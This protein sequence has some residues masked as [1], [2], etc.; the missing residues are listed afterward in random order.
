M[1]SQRHLSCRAPAK[2][3]SSTLGP[4]GTRRASNG[5]ISLTNITD[6]SSIEVLPR[7]SRMPLLPQPDQHLPQPPPSQPDVLALMMNTVAIQYYDWTG[8]FKETVSEISFGFA[9]SIL[10]QV[11][12]ILLQQK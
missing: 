3:R 9:R 4:D 5:L 11:D 10:T 2:S 12:L 7:T 6:R 8:Y 1:A